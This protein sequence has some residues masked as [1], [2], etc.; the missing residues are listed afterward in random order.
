MQ[1]VTREKK[2]F[3]IKNNAVILF[4]YTHNQYYKFEPESILWKT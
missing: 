2:N 3:M 4:E 1:Q